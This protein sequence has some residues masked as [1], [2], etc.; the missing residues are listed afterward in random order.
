MDASLSPDVGD[1]VDGP[2]NSMV[3]L[4]VTGGSVW[5]S[6]SNVSVLETNSVDGESVLTDPA[7]SDEDDP[8]AGTEVGSTDT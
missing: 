4:A 5:I 8:V 7:D 6:S 3:G 2:L 1:P